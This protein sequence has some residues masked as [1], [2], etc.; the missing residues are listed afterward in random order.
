MKIRG[1]SCFRL[2][3]CLCKADGAGARF[4]NSLIRFSTPQAMRSYWLAISRAARLD[5]G[6]LINW[7]LMRTSSA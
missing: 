3:A 6:G 7:D 4:S 1:R 5:P 2:I